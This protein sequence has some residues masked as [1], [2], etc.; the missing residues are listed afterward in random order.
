MVYLAAG[1]PGPLAP[2]QISRPRSIEFAIRGKAASRQRHDVGIRGAWLSPH[3]VFETGEEASGSAIWKQ[4]MEG[5]TWCLG[6]RRIDT[7]AGTASISNCSR[8]WKFDP[9][10]SGVVAQMVERSLSMREVR[11]SIPRDSSQGCGNA[12]SASCEAS[13]V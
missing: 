9:F 1:S 4:E 7:A 2:K 8:T 13:V 12:S 6:T 11:G 5:P 3:A 10:P